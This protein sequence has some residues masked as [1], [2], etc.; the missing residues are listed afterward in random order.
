MDETLKE[1]IR[2]FLSN[3]ITATN[4]ACDN[5]VGAELLG[6]FRWAAV[7]WADLSCHSAEFYMNEY[8]SFGYRVY[9]EEA[10][11]N[12]LELQAFIGGELAKLGFPEVTVLT[13]W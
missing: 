3:L 12:N 7:N 11:P 2:Q 5:A 9:I 8:G 10:D 4:E 6:R 1:S 13:E